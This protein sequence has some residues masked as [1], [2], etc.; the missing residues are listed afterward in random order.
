ASL[1]TIWKDVGMAMA[2]LSCFALLLYASEKRSKRA[3]F[4]AVPFLFYGISV[5]HNGIA[6]A[7][8]LAL[9]AGHLFQKLWKPRSYSYYQI[10]SAVSLALLLGSVAISRGI[11]IW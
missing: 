7:L 2:F 5:R 10:V 6:A 1:S 11:T 9:W 8:P 4:G 3:F